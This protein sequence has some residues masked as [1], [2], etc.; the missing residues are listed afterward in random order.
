VTHDVQEH[1]YFLGIIVGSVNSV[2]EPFD[3]GLDVVLTVN[4]QVIAGE[5]IPNWAWFTGIA[6]QYRVATIRD[7][8]DPDD[9]G[10]LGLGQI[11]KEQGESFAAAGAEDRQA[12][13]ATESLPV[14]YRQAI[15]SVA[16]TSYIHLRNARIYT[17]GQP[18][19]PANGMLWRGRL[20]EVSGWTLGTPEVQ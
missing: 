1:D 12:K 9:E 11:F 6:D 5:I 7:G 4:G 10:E 17:P 18:P 16:P 19:L 3:H 2:A 14:P 20:S 15:A 8:R 13:E